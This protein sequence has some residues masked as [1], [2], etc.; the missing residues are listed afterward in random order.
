MEVCS[1]NRAKQKEA[2]LQS[3]VMVLLMLQI[4]LGLLIQ[5]ELQS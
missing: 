5:H 3:V 2:F 4:Q 1:G